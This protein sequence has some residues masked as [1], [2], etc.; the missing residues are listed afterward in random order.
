MPTRKFLDELSH[1]VIGACIEVHRLLGPGLLESIYAECLAAEL[2]EL[3]VTVKKEV[4]IPIQYKGK[5]LSKPL[6]LDLLVEDSIIV[7]AKSVALLMPVH[8]A[9]LLTYLKMTDLKLGLLL[10]FNVVVMRD[11]IK[12]IVNGL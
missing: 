6:R 7:E 11:G 10:N 4:V 2:S 9:Q 1:K 8:S 12:R 3:G 5:V